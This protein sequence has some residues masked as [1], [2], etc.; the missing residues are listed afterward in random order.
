MLTFKT[1]I[2]NLQCYITNGY[3]S[4]YCFILLYTY[5]T[6]YTY[7]TRFIKCDPISSPPLWSQPKPCH[8]SG[9]NTYLINCR[10]DYLSHKNPPRAGLIKLFCR[11][12]IPVCYKHFLAVLS[13]LSL[14]LCQI[15]QFWRQFSCNEVWLF[16]RFRCSPPLWLSATYLIH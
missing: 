13:L 4:D 6:H 3:R 14:L 5:I 10:G 12:K 15:D 16:G 2:H 11:L 7:I 1:R 8:P 9:S